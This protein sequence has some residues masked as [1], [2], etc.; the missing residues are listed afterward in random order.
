MATRDLLLQH[1]RKQIPRAAKAPDAS[2]S[3]HYVLC[4]FF[5]TKFA[6]FIP[7]FMS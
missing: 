1:V 5:L 4:I 6:R 3:S 2:L 7:G